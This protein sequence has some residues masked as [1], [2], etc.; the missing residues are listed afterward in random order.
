VG[1][2]FRTKRKDNRKARSKILAHLIQGGTLFFP[3]SPLRKDLT[4]QRGKT[5]IGFLPLLQ[6]NARPIQSGK[7]QTAQQFFKSTRIGI[8]AIIPHFFGAKYQGSKGRIGQSFIVFH[9]LFLFAKGM[10]KAKIPFQFYI[11]RRNQKANQGEKNKIIT[12]KGQD[13]GSAVL[14]NGMAQTAISGVIQFLVFDEQFSLVTFHIS[15]HK[16]TSPFHFYH[17][18]QSGTVFP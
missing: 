4:H 15:K 11:F 9:S 18:T 6:A 5:L 1:N 8:H 13:T 3:F 12:E 17:Y 10:E 7:K 14:S 16:N 2:S